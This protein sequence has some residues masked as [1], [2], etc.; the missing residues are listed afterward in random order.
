MN[1]R[2]LEKLD[3]LTDK[4][5]QTYYYTSKIDEKVS[6]VGDKLDS[7]DHKV[8][9]LDHRLDEL[10]KTMIKQEI[11]LA[12]HMRRTEIL[13][14]KTELNA[15]ELKPVVAHVAQLKGIGKAIGY[16]SI[17]VGL[18]ATVQRLLAK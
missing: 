17:I 4:V 15:A 14:R 7:L 16:L 5:T 2:I 12:E 1:D 18:A 9:D 6:D 11:N 3:Q 13:E 10:D 8:Q